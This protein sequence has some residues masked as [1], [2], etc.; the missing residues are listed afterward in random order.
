[1]GV[2]SYF[3]ALSLRA[4]GNGQAAREVLR[5]LAEFARQQMELEPKI[6]YFATSLP[7]LLL[8]D[9]DLAKRNRIDSLVLAALANQGLGD[10]ATASAQFEQV[11]ADDPSHLFA[12]DMLAWFKQR[13]NAD[14]D[15]TEEQAAS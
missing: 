14:A 1:M 8:F 9:D 3:Q 5:S 13:G 4:L 12:A 11:L 2:H 15:R 10:V 7:N 6:D